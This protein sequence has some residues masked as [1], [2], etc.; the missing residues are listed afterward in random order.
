MSKFVCCITF[1]ERRGGGRTYHSYIVNID[2]KFELN[3]RQRSSNIKKS[4]NLDVFIDDVEQVINGQFDLTKHKVL[5][6]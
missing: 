3:C 5:I 2:G 4:F 6:G 1:V